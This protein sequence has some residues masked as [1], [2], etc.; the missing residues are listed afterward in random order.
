MKKM[1][2]LLPDGVGVRNFL[3]SPF[4]AKCRHHAIDT[5][6]WLPE[7]LE[8]NL[9]LQ[10]DRLLLPAG[11]PLSFIANVVRMGWQRVLLIN[12]AIAFKNPVYYSYIFPFSSSFSIR[13]TIQKAL[14]GLVIV[15]AK[16]SRKRTR[17][18]KKFYL[19]LVRHSNYYRKCCA[20]LR[21]TPVD[22]VF[23]THQRASAAVAPM[24]AAR[25]QGIPTACFIYSWD[26]LPKASLFVEADY[27][28]VWSQHM[29]NELRYYYPE[30]SPGQIKI[31]GTPQFVPYFDKVHYQSREEV[32][33]RYNLPLSASW[34]CF[35][36]DD[37]TTSPYD[38]N[39]LEDMAASVS[40]WNESHP[41]RPLHIVFRRCPVDLSNRFDTI[42]ARYSDI[43]T[44]IAPLWNAPDRN[45]GWDVVIPSPADIPLLVNLVRHCELVVNVGSTMAHDFAVFEKP[46]IYINYQPASAVD[47]NIKAVYQFIHFETMAGLEP[48]IW[49]NHADEWEL[50][51]ER[52]LNEGASFATDCKKWT[53]R[54]AMHPLEDAIDRLVDTIKNIA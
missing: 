19:S 47:W 17:W 52:G 42:L 25:A 49:L 1:L 33:S 44:P 14:V 40:R 5:T 12:R 28:F 39:Y 30:I 35:S 9:S 24:L 51:L 32:S 26:N 34:L 50:V 16:Y 3:F 23:C 2:V 31:V 37:V 41:H 38:S 20:V 22:F 46:C 11:K 8:R 43:I 36:G 15:F 13:K 45:S 10:S 4:R 6:L 27:Y 29:Y 54:I 18:V 53:Q 7:S 21:A 48:V